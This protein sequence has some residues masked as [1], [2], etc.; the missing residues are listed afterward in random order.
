MLLPLAGWG[1]RYHRIL[2]KADL[3]AGLTVAVVAVTFFSTLWINIEF[4]VYVG[5]FLSIA[6][7][8]AKTAHP[9]IQSIVPDLKT[10]KMVSSA[11]GPQCCQMDILQVEGS[12]F[13]GSATYVQEELRFRL[14]HHVEVSPQLA[15]G[16]ALAVAVQYFPKEGT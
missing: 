14:A 12:L 3:T 11:L 16:N 8:L 5:A 9:R 6:L 2:F 1:H 15:A 10:G 4:A 13:F 7:H